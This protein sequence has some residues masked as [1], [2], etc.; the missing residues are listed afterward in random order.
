MMRLLSLCLA[1]LACGRALAGDAANTFEADDL[2]RLDAAQVVIVGEVHDNPAHHQVQA[3]LAQR[4]SPAAIVFEMLSEKQVTAITPEIRTD[5]ARL[6]AALDWEDSGWP[7]FAMYYPILAA[8][9]DAKIYPG[10]MD[11]AQARAAMEDGLAAAFGSEAGAYGL[12][13]A[14]A[15]T[16]QNARERLQADAHCGALPEEMLPTMVAI[17]RLRDAVL[18]RAT[19]QALE[20]TGGPVL[21]ITGNGHAR[22]DW[23][24]PVFLDKQ[25][26]DLR[27]VVVGQGEDGRAPDGGF[28]I[29]LDAPAPERGDPCEAF[30]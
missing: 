4:L 10:L 26:P 29:V 8:A 1:I 15:A 14:L 24:M 17:Q 19:L 20:E 7:D 16:E 22:A 9:P 3:E 18:A 5:E 21:V 27:V 30:R 2:A 25:R 6:R 13:T 23:G 28:D 12:D 11:R